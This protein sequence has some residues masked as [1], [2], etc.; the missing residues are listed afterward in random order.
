PQKH[1]WHTI[2]V[3][4]DGDRKLALPEHFSPLGFMPDGAALYGSYRVNST[5]SLAIVPLDSTKPIRVFSIPSGMHAPII[6]PDG[7]RFAVL[8]DPSPRD[9]LASV[10]TVVENDRSSVYV[11]GADGADG[12]WWCPGLENVGEVAWSPDGA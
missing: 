5:E 4:G 6:S 12:G 10:R 9:T 11:L 3:S 8:A 1:E 2:G 7:K